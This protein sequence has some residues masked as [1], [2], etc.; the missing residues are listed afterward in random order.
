MADPTVPGSRF[1]QP[2]V[3]QH[4]LT[5]LE[6]VPPSECVWSHTNSESTDWRSIPLLV[7]IAV[8]EKNIICHDDLP[9]TPVGPLVCVAS[10]CRSI[11][12]AKPQNAFCIR[13]DD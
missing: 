3:E 1:F 7:I 13:A 9:H 11:R 8:L 10:S 6:A 2:T 5:Q 12:G 4:T